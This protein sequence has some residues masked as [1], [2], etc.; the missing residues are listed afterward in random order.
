MLLQIILLFSVY[1]HWNRV[2]DM[3][4][5]NKDAVHRKF[6]RR[7]LNR[8][9]GRGI[10][11]MSQVKWTLPPNY[12]GDKYSSGTI[13]HKK[14]GICIMSIL[15]PKKIS[16]KHFVLLGNSVGKR[17]GKQYRETGYRLHQK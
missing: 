6:E 7:A 2:I 1:V 9:P 16:P 17:V 3:C 14:F 13:T 11:L 12:N 8:V 10:N 4:E 5:A 15:T